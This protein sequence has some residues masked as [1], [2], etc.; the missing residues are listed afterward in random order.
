[1]IIPLDEAMDVICPTKLNLNAPLLS[2]RH[3]GG[4]I[5]EEMACTNSQG[6][7]QNTSERIPFCWELAPGKPKDSPSKHINNIETDTPRPKTPPGRWCPTKVASFDDYGDD[8]IVAFSGIDDGFDGDVD[9]DGD[10]N[11]DVFSKEIDVLSLTEAI[12]IVEKKEKHHGLECVKH[13]ECPSPSFIIE[14][15]LPDAAA[16]AASSTLNLSKDMNKKLPYSCV[17]RQVARSY[18]S[19]KGCGLQVLF[20]RRL[21][22]KL[23]GV[24]GPV[25]QGSSIVQ[26][27]C[28]PNQRK[29]GS[30]ANRP[31][32]N[33]TF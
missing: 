28:G 15:F 31:N 8:D 18:P 19:P 29:H 27:Q 12:D 32:I 13:S 9:D 20:P 30:S 33:S 4:Q 1:M 23:C 16:L 3:H 21:K 22:H 25:C 2:T 24:K 7:L 14:R 5:G 6:A 10:D 17:S 11:D 26:P